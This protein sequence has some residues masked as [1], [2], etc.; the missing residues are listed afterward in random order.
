MKPLAR[1][2][3]EVQE[4]KDFSQAQAETIRELG[5]MIIYNARETKRPVITKPRDIKVQVT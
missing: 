2:E 5:A 3:E 1:L 4:L